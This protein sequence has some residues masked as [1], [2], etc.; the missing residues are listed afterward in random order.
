MTVKGIHSVSKGDY[1]AAIRYYKAALKARP[2]DRG[3]QMALGQVFYLKDKQEGRIK[4]N[5]KVEVLLDALEHGKGDWEASIR[6]LENVLKADPFETGTR[7]STKDRN[8][9]LAI[10]DALNYTKGLY[11]ESIEEENT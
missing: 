10:R 1:E 5:P 6:Y 8:R 9:A 3:I 7:L 2:N 4:P 11:A